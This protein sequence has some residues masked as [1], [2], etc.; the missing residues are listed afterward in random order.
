MAVTQKP[1]TKVQANLPMPV[2]LGIMGPVGFPLVQAFRNLAM[3]SPSMLLPAGEIAPEL[4]TWRAAAGLGQL[5]AAAYTLGQMLSDLTQRN[6]EAQG[7]PS[8]G[9][10]GPTLLDWFSNVYGSRGG[11]PAEP[12]ATPG[13]DQGSALPALVAAATR[14][15][16][17]AAPA[18]SPAA[19]QPAGQAIPRFAAPGAGPDMSMLPVPPLPNASPTL[20][21]TVGANAGKLLPLLGLVGLA[22]LLARGNQKQPRSGQS[23]GRSAAAGSLE[24]GQSLTVPKERGFL[25]N[26][27]AQGP[28]LAQAGVSMIEAKQTEAEKNKLLALEEQN[29][30]AEFMLKVASAIYSNHLSPTM[31]KAMLESQG[32]TPPPGYDDQ[33]PT[34]S[35]RA[36]AEYARATR[37]PE[38]DPKARRLMSTYLD[39]RTPS[40]LKRAILKVDG[41]VPQELSSWAGVE[42][43]AT[44]TGGSRG[45][46]GGSRPMTAN[47]QLQWASK[48]IVVAGQLP[49]DDPA[50]QE[51]LK[52]SSSGGM[53]QTEKLTQASRLINMGYQVEMMSNQKGAA[54]KFVQEGTRLANEAL[55]TGTAPA[56]GGAAAGPAPTSQADYVNMANKIRANSN[57]TRE[58]IPRIKAR[59][60]A[61][62]Y[63]PSNPAIQAALDSLE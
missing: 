38:N 53:T 42:P 11:A 27:L 7:G 30:K 18:S 19:T 35:I 44:A 56:G 61:N 62:G 6:Q 26:L 34:A 28:A 5:P 40:A 32:I 10:G 14:S 23:T 31:G 2:P 52:R 17:T 13:S 46:A 4:L 51:A 3:P 21:D 55:G 43:P 59:L 15:Q 36:L 47:Q 60:I 63:D 1:K 37:T 57:L 25:G 16:P 54:A 48:G 33:D 49:A 24:R 58:D 45:T 41:V 50:I 8:L 12:Q 29:R 9:Y 22:A 39:L 20:G